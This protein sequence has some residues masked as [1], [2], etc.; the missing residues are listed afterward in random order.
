MPESTTKTTQPKGTPTTGEF[1]T[2]PEE[3]RDNFEAF[4]EANEAII[5]GLVALNREAMAFGNKRLH[6][7]FVQS[8]SL[9]DCKWPEEAFRIQCEFLHSAT[10]QYLAQTNHMLAAMTKM[11]EEFWEPLQARTTETLRA[12]DQERS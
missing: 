9:A 8:E 6:E 2:L 3:T 5:K 1:V 12:L 11:A 4:I 7:N 10:R